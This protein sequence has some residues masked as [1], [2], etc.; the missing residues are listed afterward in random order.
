MKLCILLVGQMRTYETQDI[1]NSYNYLSKYGNIDLYIYIWKNKG[2]SNRHGNPNLNENQNDI[3]IKEDIIN[4]YS[5]LKFLNIKEIIIDD[6]EIFY[7]SLTEENKSIYNTPFIH[8]NMMFARVNTSLPIQF[9]YQQSIKCLYNQSY[10]NVMII[11]PDMEILS[12]IPFLNPVE[13]IIYFESECNKCMDHCWFGKPD[14]I[15]KQ[16]HNIFDNYIINYQIVTTD[17][18]EMLIYQCNI[19]NIQI[20]HLYKQF[21]KQHYFE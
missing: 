3:I 4:H 14:T 12:D 19:N 13:N 16:L 10:D 7:N 11:R 17:N 18:N 5:K 21:V 15:I 2:Y 9:K 8:Q 6:F 20:Q 1:L